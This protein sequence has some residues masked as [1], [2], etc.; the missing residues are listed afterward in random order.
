MK[1][2][3][4]LILLFL[5]F[6]LVFAQES[7]LDLGLNQGDLFLGLNPCFGWST[8]GNSDSDFRNNALDLGVKFSGDYFLNDQIS[9]G[10]SLGGGTDRSSTT[11]GNFE[12][13]FRTNFLVFELSANYFWKKC[14]CRGQNYVNPRIRPFVGLS[15]HAR[16]GT[17]LSGG[18]SFERRERLGGLGVSFQAGVL[19]NLSEEDYITFEGNLLNLQRTRFRD[20]DTGNVLSTN[21]SFGTFFNKS[22]LSV[23]FQ[24]RF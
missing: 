13:F 11:D 14:L 10:A 20:T 19:L 21:N 3:I 4:V 12:S 8:S 22:L 23:N 9:V 6:R 18:D 2:S 1:H 15:T 17:A 7:D 24:R 5:S 16:R